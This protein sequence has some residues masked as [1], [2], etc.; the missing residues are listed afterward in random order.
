M[1]EAV[2]RRNDSEFWVPNLTQLC[3]LA[4]GNSPVGLMSMKLGRTEEAIRSRAANEGTR[5]L[6]AESFF[7]R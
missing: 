3:E 4:Q 6:T 5:S 2:T 7:V 1:G